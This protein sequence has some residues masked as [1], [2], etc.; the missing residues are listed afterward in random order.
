LF[1]HE[2][3]K[4]FFN[5]NVEKDSI[6]VDIEFPWTINESFV[7]AYPEYDTIESPTEYLKGFRKY[8]DENLSMMTVTN[9]KLNILG[10]EKM[11]VTGHAHQVNYRVYYDFGKIHEVKNT[12]MFNLNVNQ[13]NYHLLDGDTQVHFLT[14]PENESFLLENKKSKILMYGAASA[15]LVAI[16]L[17]IFRLGNARP[18]DS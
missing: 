1:A 18:K 15:G 16:T 7:I 5:I 8:I 11:L 2:S 10:I 9:R 6:I 13:E 4:A 14:T 3:N 17:I 12:T